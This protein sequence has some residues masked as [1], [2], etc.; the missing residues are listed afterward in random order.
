MM[1][2]K[3]T[4]AGRGK[5]SFSGVERGKGTV[6]AANEPEV[7]KRQRLLCWRSCC[8]GEQTK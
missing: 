4:T 2:K 5:S 7:K 6:K 8:D 1:N 3:H